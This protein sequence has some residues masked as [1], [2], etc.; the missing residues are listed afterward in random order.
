MVKPRSY[1]L[2]FESRVNLNLNLRKEYLKFRHLFRLHT[3]LKI[4][5]SNNNFLKLRKR[6]KIEKF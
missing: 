1:D 5:R 3:E 6:K 4:I 2:K